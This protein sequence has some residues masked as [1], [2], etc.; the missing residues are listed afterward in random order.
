MDVGVGPNR[1]RPAPRRPGLRTVEVGEQQVEP[2][3]AAVVRSV[4]ACNLRLADVLREPE[5]DPH[6]LSL[7]ET[8]L[9]LTPDE[10]LRRLIDYVR[11]VRAGRQAMRTR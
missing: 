7:L 2:G 10:R 8:T 4:E 3:F 11:F 1:A 6:D 9:R 5:A